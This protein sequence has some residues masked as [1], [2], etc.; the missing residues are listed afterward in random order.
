MPK[1]QIYIR[2]IKNFV[3]VNFTID[4]LSIDWIDKL[5]RYKDDANKAFLF[6]D[7]QIN[8]LLNKYMT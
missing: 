3:R 4:Y 8:H 5:N 6:F 2:D 7:W 1:Q